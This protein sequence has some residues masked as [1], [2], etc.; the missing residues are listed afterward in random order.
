MVFWEHEEHKVAHS[1]LRTL[2][3]WPRNCV[4]GTR[5]AQSGLQLV[6]DIQNVAW[7]WC[8]AN[9]K[10][11]KWLTVGSGHSKCCL[12]VVFWELEEHEVAYSLLRTFKMLPGN[13]VLA[14]CT[15]IPDKSCALF[16][17]TIS[18]VLAWLHRNEDESHE[19]R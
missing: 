5:R 17:I 4:W 13:G 1:W 6:P 8:S 19:V 3:M 2:K 12:G 9:T 7:E 16:E 15:I 11:T 10:S 18:S 14:T